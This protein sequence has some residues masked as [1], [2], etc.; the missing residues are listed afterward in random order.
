[1]TDHG[2]AT[3]KEAL[4][5][6]C[7]KYLPDFAPDF[8]QKEGEIPK[9]ITISN[10]VLRLGRKAGG[11]ENKRR[12]KR[13]FGRGRWRR[14]GA[15]AELAKAWIPSSSSEELEVAAIKVMLE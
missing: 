12:T 4:T 9:R 2:K 10:F 14:K 13:W 15:G 6:F 8:L 3:Y 5:L 11:A 7:S 1:V